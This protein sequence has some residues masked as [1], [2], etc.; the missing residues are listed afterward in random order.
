MICFL[1]TC[2]IGFWLKGR[3]VEIEQK[4][5]NKNNGKTVI[6]KQNFEAFLCLNFHSLPRHHKRDNIDKNLKFK[7]T[8]DRKA[9]SS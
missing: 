5:S 3:K 9:I 2:F 6:K 1:I 4:F 7:L 8:I